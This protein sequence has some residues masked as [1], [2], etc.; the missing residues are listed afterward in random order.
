MMMM[1]MM[2]MIAAMIVERNGIIAIAD[3]KY[4][5]EVT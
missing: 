1:M 2:M 5:Q 4:N 3:K